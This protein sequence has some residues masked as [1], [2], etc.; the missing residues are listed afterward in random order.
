MRRDGPELIR[1][2][3]HPRAQ[4]VD[5]LI[6]D[7]RGN[8]EVGRRALRAPPAVDHLLEQVEEGGSGDQSE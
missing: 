2:D 6:H 1:S 7:R 8:P 4:K 5:V 3:H